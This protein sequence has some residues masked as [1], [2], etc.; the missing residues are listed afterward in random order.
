MT[1][2]SWAAVAAAG[3]AAA[4]ST[5]QRGAGVDLEAPAAGGSEIELMTLFDAWNH[6]YGRR[7][8]A[9]EEGS[10]E[11]LK[12]FSIF[13]DTLAF[14]EA[15]NSDKSN[16]HT[17]SLNEFADLTIEEFREMGYVQ[18]RIFPGNRTALE[19]EADQARAL[20]AQSQSQLAQYDDTAS[21]VL[22][23]SLPDFVD[24]RQHG[25][26]TPAFTQGVN[27]DS[28]WAVAAVGAVE[29]LY[30]I[31]TGSLLRASV[32]QVV[33]CSAYNGCSGGWPSRA[34]DWIQRNGLALEIDYPYTSGVTG[35]PGRCRNPQTPVIMQISGH[36]AVKWHDEQA[37]MEAVARQPVAVAMQCFTKEFAL[38][39]TGVITGKDCSPLTLDHAMLMVGYGTDADGVAYWLIQNSWGPSWGEDG[40][41]RVQ[42]GISLP[43]GVCNILS[44][45]NEYPIMPA[46]APL[47]ITLRDNSSQS[48]IDA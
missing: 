21:H 42:R 31:N 13:K 11:K 18:A 14:I 16:G 1:V 12:R 17:V 26:V 35:K 39:K 23:D 34:F 48:L 30:A 28:C 27:C 44:R 36:Q 6:K 15:H 29:S 41:V 2:A 9:G 8:A 3:A 22:R 10:T 45:N 37:L 46:L 20:R 5:Q 4:G 25:V 40:Y 43:F 19:V 24:W 7:Y 38:Y 33:S 32:E 47:S